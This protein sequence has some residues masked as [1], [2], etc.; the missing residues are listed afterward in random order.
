M[1]TN[2][3]TSLTPKT[4]IGGAY[5]CLRNYTNPSEF[6]GWVKTGSCDT[7]DNTGD[8]L[9][10]TWGFIGINF[11]VIRNVPDIST[12][13]L[14]EYHLFLRQYPWLPASG[15]YY[16]WLRIYYSD[17]SYD[18]ILNGSNYYYCTAHWLNGTFASSKTFSYI[19]Y[20]GFFAIPVSTHYFYLYDEQYYGYMPRIDNWTVQPAYIGL[21]AP[22]VFSAQFYYGA[23]PFVTFAYEM[24]GTVTYSLYADWTSPHSY[25]NTTSFPREG[26]YS[27]NYIA[28][29]EWGNTTV[30]PIYYFRVALE[31]FPK[32]SYL[33]LFNALSGFPL[34]SKDFKIFLGDPDSRECINFRSYYGNW[35]VLNHN[36]IVNASLITNGILGM[37]ESVDN[38]INISA[39][40]NGLASSFESGMIYNTTLW[41]VLEF[42]V[43]V[44]QPTWIVIIYNPALWE[45]D[46]YLYLGAQYVGFWL[47]IQ[48]PFFNFTSYIDV[49]HNALYELGWWIENATV[50]LA[51]IRVASYYTWN[52]SAYVADPYRLCSVQN[53]Q[54]PDAMV[55]DSPVETICIQDFFNNTLYYADVAYTPFLDI[56]LPICLFTFYNWESY[57]IIIRIYRGLGTFIEL[58]VPPQSSTTQE[59]FCTNYRVQITNQ[60]IQT[61]LI[62]YVS[63][64][65]TLNVVIPWG[66][67]QSLTFP[68]F[69]EQ[70]LQFLFH[71]PLGIFLFICICAYIGLEVYRGLRPPKTILQIPKVKVPKREKELQKTIR[72]IKNKKGIPVG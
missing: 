30:T 62:T 45:K 3:G 49:T 28:I 12:A 7:F 6:L 2:I 32:K 39:Y 21:G 46:F 48:I 42:Q 61:L 24:G 18:E 67:N 34:V 68:N 5:V 70:L 55:F 11:Y 13:N 47:D 36:S 15:G 4:S 26:L 44:F 23:T 14:R 64:N 29:G 40:R 57:S 31:V 43:K 58:A 54:N 63:P 65:K 17:S 66:Y 37:N 8:K 25:W 56:G 19:Q 35:S 51:N 27:Y 16:A 9:A 41:T 69:W 1:I 52:G 53:R 10:I 60:Q 20:K 22:T 33:S 59:V 71:T 50:L 72:E 38:Y